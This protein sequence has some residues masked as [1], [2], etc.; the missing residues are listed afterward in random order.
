MI[1]YERHPQIRRFLEASQESRHA[2][3]LPNTDEDTLLGVIEELE[4]LVRDDAQAATMVAGEIEL[5]APK[6][7]RGAMAAR[8]LRT[9]AAAESCLGQF[10]DAIQSAH[11]AREYAQHADN[12]VEAARALIA[13][14]QPMC[15]TGRMEEAISHGTQAHDELMSLDQP[16]LAA[17][18]NL[19]LG[20]IFKAQGKAPKAI[21]YL[22]QVIDLLPSDDPILP[23]ALN[24][25]GECMA[26]DH[27]LESADQVYLRAEGM[28]PDGGFESAVVTGN[29]AELAAR[30]ARYQSA[31]DLFNQSIKT[32]RAL[33]I[34]PHL[35]RMTV[36]LA[37]V[38]ESCGLLQ[39]AA[40]HLMSTLPELEELEIAA[41]L[42]TA[43]HAHG[44]IQ[45]RL[46][47]S[48]SAIDTLDLARRAYHQIGN[49]RFADRALLA[50]V[51]ACIEENRLLEAATRLSLIDPAGDDLLVQSLRSFHHSLLAEAN[52]S[53]DEALGH[54][55]SS[56]RIASEIGLRPLQI[57][58]GARRAHLLLRTGKIDDAISESVELVQR[59]NQIR[60][61]F[62]SQR[63]R[64]AFL[65]TNLVAHQTAVTGLVAK[66]GSKSLEQA[67]EIAE[68][69]KN[70]GLI[71]R[72][73]HQLPEPTLNPEAGPEIELIKSKLNAL[74]KSLEQ[75]GFRE[76][77]TSARSDRQHEIDQLEKQLE[78]LID[79]TL[80][81]APAIDQPLSYS[82]IVSE[83]PDDT[84][85]VEYVACGEELTVFNIGRG[86]IA[87]TRLNS[88]VSEI[89]E[90]VAQ[91]HFQ[92]RR[93]LRGNVGPG[94]EKSM[95]QSTIQIL[96]QLY[97]RLFQPITD[98]VSEF[99]RLV[100]VPQGPLSGIPFH[101]LHDGE[102]YLIDRHEVSV[103]ASAAMAVRTASSPRSGEGT[104]V[105]TVGDELAPSIDQEGLS[106]TAMHAHQ[107]PTQHVR[108]DQA[109]VASVSHALK[110]VEIAHIACHARF[111]PGSPRSSGLRLH[112]RWFTIRDV[113][114]LGRTP[115]VVILSGCETGLHS[116]NGSDEL[117]GLTRGFASGGTRAVV[118]SL[119]SVNDQASTRLM[120]DL[121]QQLAGLQ[122][123][124][125]GAVTLLLSKSQRTLRSTHPHPA[126]WAPFFC[127][128]GIAHPSSTPSG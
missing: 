69:A 88:T 25:L 4:V 95:L 34:R 119:W 53:L 121:H 54:V 89:T 11:R 3:S 112:D 91:L 24:A 83:L 38:L 39:D 96:Q 12:P 30:Q 42:A 13:A 71:E 52:Q 84:S 55:E 114:E 102:D 48:A 123:I 22:Q 43:R 98:Q 33:E 113:H 106:V 116:D 120:S 57:E 21:P 87:A 15:N 5:I 46:G 110:G 45:I 16:E 31:L 1:N 70:R 36:E 122:N 19:N 10:S 65:S 18:A 6:A 64:A 63:F 75:D 108:G 68:Q 58:S 85:L 44:R 60:G 23:H 66:G 20:N 118:A 104:L 35:C 99:R 76:Q 80:L 86:K 40:D 27:Q 72:L 7:G 59:I 8:A 28:L 124:D 97:D 127:S 117:L 77:R 26:Q 49:D 101:A 126:F 78:Y 61:D 74:Y 56:L 2:L 73:L 100:V 17:R 94:L 79:S 103:S 67:F 115:T 107:R 109:T 93:R 50:S 125:N 128:E 105:A 29:R 32:C 14:M 41:E 9:R 82:E 62:N 111:M 37:E 81:S 92:C 51:E 90:L 47:K